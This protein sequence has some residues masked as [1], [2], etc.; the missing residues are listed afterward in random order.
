MPCY[1]KPQD[2]REVLKSQIY[3]AYKDPSN[4]SITPLLRLPRIQDVLHNQ[5]KTD[6]QMTTKYLTN[7]KIKCSNRCNKILFN[8][9]KAQNLL[10]MSLA[11][12][13]ENEGLMRPMSTKTQEPTIIEAMTHQ[14]VSRGIFIKQSLYRNSL[15]IT[16][17]CLLIQFR[18]NRPNKSQVASSHMGKRYEVQ[19][20]IID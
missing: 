9:M 5:I 6:H 17:L 20:L 8:R 10:S 7:S 19:I 12:L 18:I 13:L 14:E 15:L 2:I 4:H 11:N 3:T 16:V 1:N